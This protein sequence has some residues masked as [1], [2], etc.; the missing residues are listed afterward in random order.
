MS[1]PSPA[2]VAEFDGVICFG[3]EDWWYHN[4]AHYD[5]QMMREM[6]RHMPVLYV[7][8][9]GMRVP[10][11]TEGGMFFKRVQRKL[12]SFSRGLV[13][14]R[15]D[16]SVQS[17][18]VVPGR[19][20]MK[21]SGWLLPRQV[22]RA[23]RKVGIHHPLIWVACPPGIAAARQMKHA[24]L[25]YQ[26]TDRFEC[27]EGVDADL[28][29]GFDAELKR[30]A[31]LVLY[32]SRHLFD[33]E[34]SAGHAAA[35]IDHGV[36]FGD[37]VTAGDHPDARGS[38]APAVVRAALQGRSGPRCGF[39]GDLDSAVFDADLLL[40]TAALMPDVEFVL[41]GA[42]T[43]PEGWADGAP[44][45]HLTGR[46]PYE[47]V[48]ATMASMDVLMMP[49]HRSEWIDACNPIKLKEYL[50]TG[51]PIVSTDFPELRHYEGLVAVGN[52]PETFSAAV[53]AAIDAPDPEVRDRGRERI[54]EATW[55]SRAES[56]L[57]ELEARAGL[58]GRRGPSRSGRSI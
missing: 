9:I 12:K 30:D 45:V 31:D 53:R 50:A 44:N 21:L 54:A 24:G 4:R 46:V 25:V 10:T 34:S 19:R 28:I 17:P 13:R 43:L 29:R 8:S 41:V 35:F 42:C 27:Y 20:G 58:I 14:V 56:A 51:R 18:V 52:E 49:W 2:G 39:I 16:F 6:S 48:A 11:M 36:D 55:T 23:A 22:A 1:E 15:E 47:D 33:S 7:N 57:Q 26:R 3:G 40:K 32:C 38:A 37:F 5:M